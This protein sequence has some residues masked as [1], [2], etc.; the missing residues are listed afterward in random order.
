[1]HAVIIVLCIV[2]GA[3]LSFT[4]GQDISFDQLNYHYYSAY[5]YVTDRLGQDV[6]PA[7]VMHSFFSPLIYL[8]FY[9]MVRH[10][11]PPAVGMAL[12]AVHGLNLWLVFV[13]ARIVTRSQP[14]KARAIVVLAAVMISAL[15]PMAISEF[16]TSMTDV[17][18]S[19]PVLAGVAL[20]MN[21]TM[22]EGRTIRAI[23]GIGLAGALLGAAASLKLTGAP[24][25]I[26]LAVAALIGWGSWRH[27]LLAILATALGGML[28]FAV[29][30]GAWYL[31]MWRV[32]GNP[33]F[34]Y[35]NTVFH[36]PDYPAAK[37]LFDAHFLPHGL[38]DA[39][40][41]PFRWI[42][43]QTVTAEVPFRDIRFALLIILGIAALAV[44]L[45]PGR[46][47]P[48]YPPSGR[49]LLAFFAVAFGI[50]LYI[51]SIQRYLVSLELLTGPAIV[52]LL[53]WCGLSD[54]ARRRALMV[55]AAVLAVMCAVS[56]RSPDWGHLGWRKSWYDVNV[57]PP[58]GQR[59]IYFLAGEPLSYVVP[60]LPSDAAAIGVV[61]WENL[62]TW[63]DT[64]FIRRIRD[65]L[66][67]PS[68][69]PVWAVAS[70]SPSAGFRAT[71]AAYGL[72]IAGD[73]VTTKGRP[74][75]LTWCRLVRDTAKD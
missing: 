41:Y 43:V 31:K 22:G 58:E 38:L 71:I 2:V 49:R 15:S 65:L 57:P 4:H 34:P 47:P 51:W 5:A 13:I 50:W 19:L 36:S 48:A 39:I 70:G 25:T 75:P 1:M 23:A 67:D 37:P 53:Q 35:F 64:V 26:G 44:R 27:R 14:P 52:V 40:S 42:Q 8:P 21:A 30:G 45:M 61:S 32:F 73:C 24:F 60:A 69:G 3:L 29:A 11:P 68:G 62:S 18:I 16:G 6:A 33:V 56:V 46:L 66:A 59:P 74:V 54:G 20:L 63:G 55:T 10:F 28:G 7:Q 72:G 12:G 9:F 17:V